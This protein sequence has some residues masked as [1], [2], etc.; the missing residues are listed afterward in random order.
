[1]DE[2]DYYLWDG[3]TMTGPFSH[4][5]LISMI[6]QGTT[7]PDAQ[8]AMGGSD[9]WIPLTEWVESRAATEEE[10]E[11]S[12]DIDVPDHLEEIVADAI[13]KEMKRAG[14]DV[15]ISKMP[16]G[17]HY[18]SNKIIST[19]NYT[20]D[21]GGDNIE[22][23]QKGVV[24]NDE[25]FYATSTKSP[26]TRYRIACNP[27][28]YRLFDGKSIVAR[29]N[30]SGL[31]PGIVTNEGLAVMARYC[32]N[33]RGSILAIFPNGDR[34]FTISNLGPADDLLASPDGST[35]ICAAFD[36]ED[37]CLLFFDLPSGKQTKKIPLIHEGVIGNIRYNANKQIVA[38]HYE[39]RG[40]THHY[41]FDGKCLEAAAW[42]QDR[43]KHM[44]GY[45]LFNLAKE[46]L[47]DNKSENV[48][49][50]VIDLLKSSL[51]HSVSKLTKASIHR[52]LGE[53]LATN[54]KTKHATA[55]LREALN[56]NS[57]VGCSRLLKKLEETE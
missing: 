38:V 56:L 14:M 26:N 11:F 49:N 2:N 29:G 53:S 48:P 30:E 41:T 31:G 32:G 15:T 44:S 25:N 57:K 6:A 16:E 43:I 1:M 7:P 4:D 20:D 18:S 55:H 3:Q 23:F 27:D 42:E 47:K 28:G 51:H 40:P 45:Q 35:L 50:D 34:A 21:A 52:S 8:L 24:V 12:V 13:Q 17:H 36:G 54:G 33:M 37:D 19:R 22:F 46:K 9:T 5:V 39:K 10:K